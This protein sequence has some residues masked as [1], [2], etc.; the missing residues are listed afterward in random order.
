MSISLR[1]LD[2]RLPVRNEESVLDEYREKEEDDTFNGH[3]NK[4]FAD[5]I[6]SKR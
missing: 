5:N 3:G 6:E 2:D 1:Q 4:I